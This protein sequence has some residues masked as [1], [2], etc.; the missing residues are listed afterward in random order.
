MG[1]LAISGLPTRS[2]LDLVRRISILTRSRKMCG[3]SM[4]SPTIPGKDLFPSVLPSWSCVE[5]SQKDASLSR[6]GSPLG[7]SLILPPADSGL[8]CLSL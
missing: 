1:G 7:Q 3:L 5:A 2:N 4:R 6:P 8:S